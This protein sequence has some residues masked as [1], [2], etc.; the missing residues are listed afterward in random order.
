MLPGSGNAC[1]EVNMSSYSHQTES[2]LTALLRDGDE[3]AYIEI[4]RRNWKRMYNS[5]YKRIKDRCQCEDLV[6]NVFTDLWE[7]R[8][9]VQIGNLQAYLYT[10]VRFQVI[11]F[12]TRSANVSSFAEVMDHTIVT[13]TGADAPLLETELHELFRLWIA[14]LPEKRREIFQL[15]YLENLPTDKIADM[16]GISQKTVQNQLAVASNAL[17][18]QLIQILLVYMSL[19]LYSG[20]LC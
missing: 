2:S 3:A 4:Y 9:E 18:T 5:A 16:L 12:S 15:H 1:T 7:R 6:Q 10:A 11:K 19:R 14:T 13:A 20:S 8:K 17:R